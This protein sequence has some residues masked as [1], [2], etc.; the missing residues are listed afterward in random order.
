MVYVDDFIW[1]SRSQS[2]IDNVMKSFTRGVTSNN[3]EQ[4][5]GESLSEFLGNYINTF[6]D[7]VLHFYQTVLTRKVLES[8]G[9]DH[10][11]GC[12]TPLKVEAPLR[13]EVNGSKA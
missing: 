7:G 12:T 3:L 8:I 13:T 4:S 1:W 5:K 9:I 11:N 10:C 2:D 6:D